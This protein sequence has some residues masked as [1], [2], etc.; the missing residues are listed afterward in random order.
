MAF[1]GFAP[2]FAYISGL[3]PALRLPRRDSPR[4]RVPLGSVALADQ[5]TGVYP[6]A[7]PGGWHLIGRTAL[8]VFDLGRD[9][10]AL[11]APGTPVRFAAVDARTP[12]GASTA[13]IE[14]REH[15]GRAEH[16]A[17]SVPSGTSSGRSQPGR[18]RLEIVSPGPFAT[19]QDL[20]RPGW[21]HLGITGAGALDRRSLRLA[22]RLV[23]NRE[24]AAGLELTYGGL[25][26]EFDAPGLIAVT[27]APCP[28]ELAGR[29][30]GMNS[31]VEVPAG[32]RLR[33]G[34]PSGPQALGQD[35]PA[36]AGQGL[37][38]YLAVRGG[39]EVPSVLGSRSR[40]TLAE[41][42]P[43]PLTAGDVLPIGRPHARPPVVDLAPQARFAAR[44]VLRVIPGPRDDWFPP[45]ALAT[46]W[47]ADYEVSAD[48][49]RIGMRLRGA[50]LRRRIMGELPSEGMVA[51]GIQIPP[52]GQP[53]IF[54]ADHPVTGG[55]PVVGVLTP[56][57]LAVAAQCR[58]G[59]RVRLSRYQP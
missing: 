53:V 7:S 46:L 45:D 43:A 9:P 39:V 42:G 18:S 11:L 12:A 8:P 6:R 56:D 20:G 13:G 49:D 14:T 51:G 41:L 21:A 1:C 32:A 58:P 44:P 23:G 34:F 4:T 57:D 17:A 16:L 22:N 52:D 24:S 40:D 31:P 54:L 47:T 33:V 36:V 37:R 3:D 5:F 30:I 10:P 27:G 59:Q 2:G 15:E 35:G 55:Y 38:T 29:S 19:V 26:A 50:A 28:L 25:V 48:S